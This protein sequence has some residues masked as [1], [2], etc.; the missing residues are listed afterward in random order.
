MIEQ[1]KGTK[2]ISGEDSL[3]FL[4]FRFG[5]RVKGRL[6]LT[7]DFGE[8]Q[9]SVGITSLGKIILSFLGDLYAV[10]LD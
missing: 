4:Y 5:R 7:E 9:G 8:S 10:L 1:V 2:N 3:K 6:P